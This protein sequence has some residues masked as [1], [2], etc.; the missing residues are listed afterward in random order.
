M[1]FSVATAL[2]VG[3]SVGISVVGRV[4]DFEFRDGTGGVGDACGT[5]VRWVLLVLRSLLCFC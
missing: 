2:G 5:G 3:A 4:V 1:V